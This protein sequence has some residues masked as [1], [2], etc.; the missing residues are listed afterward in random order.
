MAD[1]DLLSK[2]YVEFAQRGLP[3]LKA[4]VGELEGATRAAAKR[5]DDLAKAF[6]DTDYQRVARQA[7]EVE[8]SSR[9]LAAAEKARLDMEARRSALAS[10]RFA[11]EQRQRLAEQRAQADLAR[12]EQRATYRA[13]YG[14]TGGAVASFAAGPGGAAVQGVGSVAV[15][16]GG[17]LVRQGFQNTVESNRLA[18]ETKLAAR[19]MAGSFKPAM[20]AATRAVKS[21]RL[22]MEKRTPSE[23]NAV[24]G[25]GL[26]ASGALAS[27]FLL[28][29]VAGVGLGTA[30]ASGFGGAAAA[31]AAGGAMSRASL[32]RFLPAAALVA[33]AAAPSNI[34]EGPYAKMTDQQLE[35]ERAKAKEGTGGVIGR[36]WHS[37]YSGVRGGAEDLTNFVQKQFTG[38]TYTRENYDMKH[39]QIEDEQKKRKEKTEQRRQVTVA[40]AGFDEVGSAYVRLSNALALTDTSL[41]GKTA[42]QT[43]KLMLVELQKLTGTAGVPKPERR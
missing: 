19:E 20:D 42:E 15:G 38:K 30:L 31:G 43:L 6:S 24:M 32:L 34:R 9:R 41:E 22:W 8:Q 2:F 25:V 14:R 39:V 18:L 7:N 11:Q 40:D 16:V 29:Q 17:G 12:Q 13:Q 36:T 23:Q 21:F 33:A 1:S 28:R 27:H 5:Q 4:A 37:F 26:A 3:E 10:G 35:T